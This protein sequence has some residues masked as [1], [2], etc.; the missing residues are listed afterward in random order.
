MNKRKIALEQE[1]IFV[2][3]SEPQI[4][5]HSFPYLRV[6]YPRSQISDNRITNQSCMNDKLMNPTVDNANKCLNKNNVI[7]KVYITN[8]FS[9]KD[10]FNYN[11]HLCNENLHFPRDLTNNSNCT[12]IYNNTNYNILNNEHFTSS[13]NHENQLNLLLNFPMQNFNNPTNNCISATNNILSPQ[14]TLLN[15]LFNQL[16]PIN[17]INI[18]N[19]M[20]NN[21]TNMKENIDKCNKSIFMTF[22]N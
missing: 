14:N 16:K 2:N 13:K 19:D 18:S 11:N 5:P 17:I 10:Y 1:I 8:N 21:Q 12:S 3:K 7:P 15:N 9:N 4:N 20:K 6:D 22:F